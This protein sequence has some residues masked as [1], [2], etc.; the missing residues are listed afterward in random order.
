MALRTLEENEM[1]RDRRIGRLMRRSIGRGAITIFLLWHLVALFAWDMNGSSVLVAALRSGVAPYMTG[2]GFMQGWT[3]FA[4]NPYRRDVYV[5]ARIHHADG[6]IVSWDFPR[7]ATMPYTVRY[8]KERWRKYVEV[9]EMQEWMWPA[10]AAYAVK[11]NQR[12]G[13]SPATGVGLIRYVRVVP[14]PGQPIP[15]YVVE[16]MRGYAVTPQGLR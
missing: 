10:M 5:E 15:P 4:P 8:G 3:M 16:P 1:V 9:A 11:V 14:P 7:M 12:P 13:Q 2:T 6:S